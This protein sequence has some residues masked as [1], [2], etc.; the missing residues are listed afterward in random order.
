MATEIP[1]IK[2]AKSAATSVDLQI[3]KSIYFQDTTWDLKITLKLVLVTEDHYL[4]TQNFWIPGPDQ[5]LN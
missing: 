1:A 2:D 3:L 5:Y 4:F